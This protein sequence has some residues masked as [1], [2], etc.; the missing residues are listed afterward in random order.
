M[1]ID[2]TYR[3]ARQRPINCAFGESIKL[4]R[5]RDVKQT[6]EI[7]NVNL[8]RIKINHSQL[9]TIKYH[10]IKQWYKQLIIFFLLF[11]LSLFFIFYYSYYLY[12]L[13]FLIIILIY[14]S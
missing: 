4:L 11:L 1:P 13:L 10:Y 9:Y 8:G 12:Y 2:T 6:K 14:Y 7:L 5:Q 3:A